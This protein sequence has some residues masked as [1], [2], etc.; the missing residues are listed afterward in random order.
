MAKVRGSESAQEVLENTIEDL[1]EIIQE[2]KIKTFVENSE[3]LSPSDGTPAKTES[4]KVILV[5]E[6]SQKVAT[7]VTWLKYCCTA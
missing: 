4:N 2:L 7:A 3:A 5:K 1:N 6:Q